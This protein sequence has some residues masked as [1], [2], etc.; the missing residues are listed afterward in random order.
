MNFTFYR[1]MNLFNVNFRPPLSAAAKTC[2]DSTLGSFSREQRYL[3]KKQKSTKYLCKRIVKILP[4]KAE[5]GL[6][7]SSGHSWICHACDCYDL[8]SRKSFY[9]HQNILFCLWKSCKL[10]RAVWHTACT[11]NSHFMDYNIPI[12]STTIFLISKQKYPYYI[13]F[14][15]FQIQFAF[16]NI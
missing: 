12:R 3:H 4:A 6:Q 8:F 9:I 2:S 11:I 5:R 1:V 14:G 13:L 15:C 10:L 16:W 7:V